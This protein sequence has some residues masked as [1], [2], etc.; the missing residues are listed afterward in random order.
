MLFVLFLSMTCFFR[1]LAHFKTAIEVSGYDKG[2]LWADYLVPMSQVKALKADLAK[3][4]K[5]FKSGDNKPTSLRDAVEY[6]EHERLKAQKP[7]SAPKAKAGS[8][9]KATSSSSS[10]AR[11]KK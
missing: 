4:N 2:F 8:K 9:A 11:G 1:T 6:M 7:K 10:S 3:L 5:S